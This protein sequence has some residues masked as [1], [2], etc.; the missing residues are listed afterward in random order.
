LSDLAFLGF[1]GSWLIYDRHLKKSDWVFIVGLSTAFT[2]LFHVEQWDLWVYNLAK[3]SQFLMILL[4]LRHNPR[5]FKPIIYI[6]FVSGIIQ[7][8]IAILQFHTQT[9]LGLSF[10]GEYVPLLTDSGAAT[11]LVSG[12]KVLRAY[13]TMPHP[14]VLGGFLA[15]SLIMALYVSRGTSNIIH[16]MYVSCGTIVIIWG[17]ILSFSRSA[18]LAAIL[19]IVIYLCADVLFKRSKQSVLT[20]MLVIVSCGTL[21]VVYKNY[22]IPRSTD[23]SLSSQAANYRETFNQYGL[24]IIKQH[25]ITG[26]GLGQYVP[27]L[28]STKNLEPWAYQPPH[29]AFILLFAEIGIIGLLLMFLMFYKLCFTWNTVKYQ[30]QILNSLSSTLIGVLFVLAM[31]D[32]YLVTIQQGRLML[33]VCFGLVLINQ[34]NVSQ[35]VKHFS[36]VKQ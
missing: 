20:W 5:L 26:V 1:L 17:L 25:P 11:I 36:D 19:A 29:N 8:G 28:E 27:Y 7:A 18:W 12:Q 16:R 31:F 32:H 3:I 9:G 10:L 14:N 23:V 22:V 33:A 2:A 30:Y 21:L 24:N 15:V 6:L 4:Y 13:G 34:K 35:A